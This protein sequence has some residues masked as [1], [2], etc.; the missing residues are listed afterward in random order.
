MDK[1]VLVLDEGTTGTR[2]VVFN[3]QF[4][5]LGDSY[6]EVTQYTPS[7]DKVEHDA[8]EI[9]SKTVAMC[10]NAIIKA[11]IR[12]RDIACIGITN[13]RNTCLLWDKK[14]GKPL[15]HALVWQ[16]T[17]TADVC[18][19]IRATPEFDKILQSTGKV[20]A[21]HCSGLLLQWLINNVPGVKDKVESGDALFGTIDAWL[22]WKLTGGKVHAISYSNASSCGCLDIHKGVWDQEFL[23][24]LHLPV[25]IFPE[26]RSE[27]ADYGTTNVFGIPI[28]IT[29][30]CADQQSALFAEGCLT[31]GTV[32]CT[33]GTGSFMD[34]NIGPH[35]VIASGGLD[36]LIAWKLD[37]ETTYA[38]EGFAAVTGSAIQWLRD[39]LGIIKDSKETEELARQVED[40]NGV[41]FVPALVGLITPYQDPYA[42]GTIVGISRGVKKAHIVRATL[43]AIAFRTKDILSVVE[44]ETGV[45]ISDIKI[46]GGASSND[47]LAQMM[48]DYIDAR[49]DRP[50]SVEATS[51]GAAEFAG[52]YAGL[53][54]KDDLASAVHIEKSFMP[55]ITDDQRTTAYD[56][57]QEAV[58]RSMNWVKH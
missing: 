29:G 52:L 36:T 44:K 7:N 13:Q 5:V 15:Y 18:T 12:P 30:V 2:A 31:Q 25:S 22:V 26:V 58:K 32:K 10:K 1:Y 49:I 23:D 16:D 21:T 37:N 24:Y 45:K 6:I 17:R 47:L 38:V 56:T 35:C 48:A 51:L 8:D 55:H 34:I 27:S 3:Q 46:D 42:R 4:Q 14:T 9:Y 54:N 19:Q 50:L 40:T 41:Y 57:W 33:N 53:W 11:H 39:G 28:P 43:E 20:I